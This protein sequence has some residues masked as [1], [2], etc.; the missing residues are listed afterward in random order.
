MKFLLLISNLA[1]YPQVV[2]WCFIQHCSVWKEAA[3]FLSVCRCYLPYCQK[4]DS[5]SFSNLCQSAF[6]IGL[7]FLFVFLKHCLSGLYNLNIIYFPTWQPLNFKS[8]FFFFFFFFKFWPHY[9]TRGMWELRCGILAPQLGIEPT[10]PA[11][12]QWKCRVLIIGPPGTSL[13]SH[14][15][16]HCLCM[17]WP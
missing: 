10:L 4:L 6:F 9:M 15:G 17:W 1:I 2:L 13:K 12:L 8:Q 5:R 7:G 3:K 16:S 14:S 11:P